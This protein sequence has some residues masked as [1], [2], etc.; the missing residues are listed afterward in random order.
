M[1]VT[2]NQLISRA[3]GCKKGL[4]VA[5]TTYLYQGTLSFVNAGGY[6]DDD[7]AVGVNPFAG[8]VITGVDNSAGAN[9]ALNAEVWR[10]GEFL[11]TG[12]GFAQSS[13]GLPVYAT[14]NFTLTLTQ[15]TAGAV[16]IGKVSEYVSSTQVRVE[17]DTKSS[18]GLVGDSLTTKVVT[19]NGATG[20]NEIVIPTNLADALS[21]ESSAGDILVVDTTTGTVV[22]TVGAAVRL[23]VAG[24]AQI[25]S[26]T[27]DLVAFHGSTPTD[28]C[29]AYTQTYATADRTHANPTAA[30]LTVT[31]GAGTNDNTIGA[32]TA[33]VSVIAAVQE[34]VDEV[35][36][37]I[38]DMADV[39]QLV[40]SVIDD[41]QEKGLAG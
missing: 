39:K 35:N 17:I 26:A 7:T 21:L 10:D 36:K 37:L 18:E 41:L 38:A 16:Y 1:A 34:I 40:N 14:D 9:G 33:D 19:F 5:E 3:A 12:S 20:V 24:D 2:A 6:L 22:L 13:V 11:L 8:V 31:D 30:T 23:N 15:A 32:I 25:G 27:T 28:Q 29:A 4:P